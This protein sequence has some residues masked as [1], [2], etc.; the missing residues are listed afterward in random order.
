MADFRGTL[1]QDMATLSTYLRKWKLKLSINKT[2]SIAFHLYN[3][4]ARQEA[5]PSKEGPCPFVLNPSIWK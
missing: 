4:E 2:V 5:L 3:K 1:N